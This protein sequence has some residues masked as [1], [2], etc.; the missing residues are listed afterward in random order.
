M[1]AQENCVAKSEAAGLRSHIVICA[2]EGCMG[3]HRDVKQ[4][5]DRI[6]LY[7]LK[8]Y[9]LEINFFVAVRNIF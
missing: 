7:Q 2:S 5:N 9:I 8:I 3:L 6:V 4:R 1:Y